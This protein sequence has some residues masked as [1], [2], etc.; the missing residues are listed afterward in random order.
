MADYDNWTGCIA[1]EDEPGYWDGDSLKYCDDCGK[2]IEQGSPY[3]CTDDQRA[4]C[5]GCAAEEIDSAIRELKDVARLLQ[6]PISS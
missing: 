1:E 3:V 2:E 6:L 5:Q 4:I